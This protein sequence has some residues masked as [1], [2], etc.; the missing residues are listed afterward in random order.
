MRPLTLLPVGYFFSRSLP[1]AAAPEC[2]KSAVTLSRPMILPVIPEG[3]VSETKISTAVPGKNESTVGALVRK[4]PFLM[5]PIF[6]GSADSLMMVPFELLPV[7]RHKHTEP[8]STFEMSTSG[9]SSFDDMKPRK[10]A[11][12]VPRSMIKP[13]SSTLSTEACTKLL[14]T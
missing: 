7:M 11:S 8:S 9:P 13:W 6:C 5:L 1:L 10:F 2:I 12:P 3:V 4:V 14:V